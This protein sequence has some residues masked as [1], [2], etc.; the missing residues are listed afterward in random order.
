MIKKIKEKM[1]LFFRLSKGYSTLA[2]VSS[3]LVALLWAAQYEPSI[4]DCILAF[5]AIIFAQLGTNILNDTI[6][7]QKKLKEGKKLSEITFGNI[8]G[9]AK[10]LLN[11]E[12]S[13]KCATIIIGILY[14][15][16][17]IIGIYFT[18][19]V[20]L[21]VAAVS[22]LAGFLCVFYPIGKNFYL[23][24]IIIS[25][26]Y[27]PFVMCGTYLVLTGLFSTKILI[28][29]ISVMLLI[30]ALLGTNSIMNFEYEKSV[31]KKTFS[32]FF[33]SKKAAVVALCVLI[34]LSYLNEII[35]S[36][37]GFLHPLVLLNLITIPLGVKLIQSLFDYINIKNIDFTPKWWLSP[38]E[39]WEEIKKENKEFYMYR[40]YI[41]RNLCFIF[42]LIAALMGYLR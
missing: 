27:A 23:G 5:F 41:I 29:S 10:V 37:L 3:Y 4:I 32:T 1:S 20:G 13:L 18:R 9:K 30:L 42:C 8:T 33:P 39:D 15:V 16:A 31:A 6:D 36:L 7:V 17:I 34:C 38:A 11:G 21:N 26:L 19:K 12:V 2:V 22:L 24:E 35:F 14:L 40:I 25:I 28:F